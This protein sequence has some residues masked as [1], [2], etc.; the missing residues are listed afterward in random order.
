[1]LQEIPRPGHLSEKIDG[2]F[3]INMQI[4]YIIVEVLF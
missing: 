3:R 4:L 2:V 1:M